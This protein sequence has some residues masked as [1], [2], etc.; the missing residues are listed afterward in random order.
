[1]NLDR[2][3]RRIALLEAKRGKHRAAKH[4]VALG[5][6]ARTFGSLSSAHVTALD[7]RITAGQ[8]SDDDTS[9]LSKL[10][11]DDLAMAGMTAHEIIAIVAKGHCEF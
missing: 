8:I 11:A 10:R 2:I 9:L 1:M 5:R 3:E 4:S 6:I 7:D